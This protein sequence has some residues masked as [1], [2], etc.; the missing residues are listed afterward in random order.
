MVAAAAHAPTVAARAITVRLTGM[1]GLLIIVFIVV[2]IIELAV[3]VQVTDMIGFLPSLLLVVA[4][5]LSGAW[6]V[7]R[8]GIGVARRAQEQ[9]DNGQIPATELVN[10]LLLLGAGALMLFP[11]FVTDLLGLV[12][13]IP[14]FR[15]AIRVLLLRRFERRVRDALENPAAALFGDLGATGDVGFR[16]ARIYTGGATYGSSAV[17][18]VHEVDPEPPGGPDHREPPQLGRY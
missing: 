11:G 18:D 2:P 15:A 3:F 16:S 14:P 12:L 17:Y 1:I 9:L 7:K 13:L 4:F 6:L 10:G 8:E 5:S